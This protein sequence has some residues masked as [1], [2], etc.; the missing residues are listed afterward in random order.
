MGPVLDLKKCPQPWH[1]RV[2]RF[3]GRSALAF[4]WALLFVFC[5]FWRTFFM[6]CFPPTGSFWS[7]CLQIDRNNFCPQQGILSM[8]ALAEKCL[9]S[10]MWHQFMARRHTL[11]DTFHCGKPGQVHDVSLQW[12]ADLF[13][14]EECSHDHLP[15]RHQILLSLVPSLNPYHH[16]WP[17]QEINTLNSIAFMFLETNKLFRYNAL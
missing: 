11:A 6:G 7:F 10:S 1:G 13:L 12:A 5:Y 16:G 9:R 14:Y 15:T 4:L 3:R 17:Y 2:K 8:K